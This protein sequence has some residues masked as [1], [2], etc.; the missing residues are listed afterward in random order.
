M[1]ATLADYPEADTRAR[2]MR[3]L[4]R[5]PIFDLREEVSGY[6]ILFRAGAE[7]HY[8]CGDGDSASSQVLK[9]ML[10]L[11]SLDN[12]LAG[13]RAFVNVT[14]RL[15][16][17]DLY[18]CMPPQR[19]VVE[20]L[21]N[22]DPDHEVIEACHRLKEQG[23]TLALDDYVDRPDYLPLLRIADIVKVDFRTTPHD[24]RRTLAE[25][26]KPRG[27]QLLAEKVEN[28]Q[29]IEE[30]RSLGYSL[31]QGYFFCRP[32]VMRRRDLPA[33]KV[34][35]LRFLSEL[36]RPV[37][38][39]D[40]LE[41][42]MKREVSL[43]IKLLQ[44]LNSAVFGWQEEVKCIKHALVLL[45]A[46]RLKKWANLIAIAGLCSDK[47]P[48]L[49]TTCLVRARFA[50]LLGQSAGMVRREFDLFIA[51]LLSLMEAIVERPLSDL[52]REM[53][54]S[55]EITEALQGRDTKIGRILGLVLAYEAGDWDRSSSLIQNLEINAAVV[56]LLYS[57][58]ID[59]ARTI[60]C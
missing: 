15:L 25:R 49:L 36:N 55:A 50:E 41:R 32:E 21:E 53:A 17:E 44:Y 20:I 33:F 37:V 24:Q 46:L 18:L 3:F 59:W 27:I 38:D 12:L 35:Y 48:E 7:N 1:P 16:V 40:H 52:L 56:P 58:A 8:S 28:R 60:A 39:F 43:A 31:F 14:R 5:Q 10:G 45:G 51:G 57:Q 13:K 4:A 6:E 34:N 19:M 11:F 30:A 23:Y 2:D 9:D 47:P 29:E 54:V 26:L 42:V 22:V